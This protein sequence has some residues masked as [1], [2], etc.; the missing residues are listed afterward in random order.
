MRQNISQILDTGILIA[1]ALRR[2]GHFIFFG[3]KLEY[4]SETTATF[5]AIL[6]IEDLLLYF[7]GQI[8]V[9]IRVIDREL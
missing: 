6:V 3:I 9:I 8:K 1:I 5:N 4:F 2:S 7:C